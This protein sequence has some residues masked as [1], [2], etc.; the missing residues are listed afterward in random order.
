METQDKVFQR[1]LP[2]FVPAART[3]THTSDPLD[4]RKCHS[5]AR[6]TLNSAKA[7]AGTNPT[8]TPTVLSAKTEDGP[9]VAMATQPVWHDEDGNVVTAITD[10]ADVCCSCLVQASECVI[11]L[12]CTVA[13]AN[14]SYVDSATLAVTDLY[15][16]EEA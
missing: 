7:S 8:L 16:L 13:G 5:P 15:P 12:R 11:E 9:F 3:A 10:A 14:A 1:D 4:L 6:L 2:V